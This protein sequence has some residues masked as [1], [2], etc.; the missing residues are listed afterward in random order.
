M[1]EIRNINQQSYSLEE[2]NCC[3]E[4]MLNLVD[5]NNK[6]C[7]YKMC[8]NC[9][10]R[11]YFI[12]N[13]CPHCREKQELKFKNKINIT[14][15]RDE[16]FL[17]RFYSFTLGILLLISISIPIFVFT[18]IY[19]NN[20][21]YFIKF[22]SISYIIFNPIVTF[23]YFLTKLSNIKDIIFRFYNFLEYVLDEISEECISLF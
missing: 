14:N 12:K 8:H 9:Y 17:K 20:F 21:I 5:C 10:Y 7:K 2:C 23:N 4:K 22:I 19:T 16:Y 18:L 3:F 13:R 1:N 15:R 6:N 11:W